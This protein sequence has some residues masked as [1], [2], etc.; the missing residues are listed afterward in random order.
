MLSE[1][2][3]VAKWLTLYVNTTSEV[4]AV[5]AIVA[6]EDT[7]MKAAIAATVKTKAVSLDILTSA[8]TFISTVLVSL[9]I[10]APTF[11]EKVRTK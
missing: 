3:D 11:M 7:W 8:D 6:N 5:M 9:A 10:V 1:S 4:S 2:S